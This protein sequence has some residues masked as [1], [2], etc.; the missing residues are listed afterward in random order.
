[1]SRAP[2]SRTQH[3]ALLLLTL[4]SFANYVDRMVLNALSQPIKHEFNLSDTQLGLLTG[5]AFVLLYAFAAVPIAAL[6][7]RGSKSLVLAV[8]LAFWSIATAA[9]GLTKSYAQL[10]IARLG[11]GI[12]ESSCQPIGYALI[13]EYFPSERRATATGWFMIGNSLGVTAGLA[14]GGWLGQAYGWRAA[15]VCVGLPG[16]VLAA[17]FLM[18]MRG[19]SPAARSSP[20]ATPG[21]WSALPILL[22]N[23]AYRWVLLVNGVYSFLIFGPVAWLPAFFIR[24]HGLQLRVAGAWTGLTIGLG[25][26]VGMLLGGI[27]ADRLAKRSAAAP[28]MFCLASALATGAAYYLALSLADV[29]MAFALTFCASAIGALGSPTNVTAV[30]NLCDPRLR[31][32]AASLAT[33]TISLLG[34]GLAPLVIGMTSDALTPRFGAQALRYALM[35]SLV[36]SI[37]TAALY[38][39]VARLLRNDAGA[40]S[41]AILV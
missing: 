36:V 23:R 1:V 24:S 26:A 11:V 22:R 15:F 30:Q 18:F 3:I 21:L 33:L 8:S 7:D 6:A 37:V 34:V 32:V 14:L 28:Q 12:G 41:R 39:R 19:A 13:A 29:K 20:E 5:F 31:A 9:C 25:M 10:L 35:I 4:V 27:I 2:G 38:Y 16:L 17:V 40:G